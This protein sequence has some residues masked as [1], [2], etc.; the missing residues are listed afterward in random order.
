MCIGVLVWLPAILEG[1]EKR[2]LRVPLPFLKWGTSNPKNKN[3]KPTKTQQTYSLL[4]QNLR[5][6]SQTYESEKQMHIVAL[7][8]VY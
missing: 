8:M 1:H 6:D 3:K 4:K 5:S 7:G 2:Y